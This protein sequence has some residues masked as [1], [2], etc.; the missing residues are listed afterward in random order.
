MLF[1]AV[2][3]LAAAVFVSAFIVG[4]AVFALVRAVRENA[5]VGKTLTI[6]IDNLDD[7]TGLL[8]KKMGEKE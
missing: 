3:V 4:N 6:A 2:F 5:E 8:L 1:T 7:V